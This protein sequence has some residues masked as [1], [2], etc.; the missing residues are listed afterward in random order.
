[1][2][3]LQFTNRFVP[4]FGDSVTGF[5]TDVYLF[6]LGGFN[7]QLLNYQFEKLTKSVNNRSQLVEPI[8]PSNSILCS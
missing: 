5:Q 1:M 2:K 7:D 3:K 8:S 4:G 6:R